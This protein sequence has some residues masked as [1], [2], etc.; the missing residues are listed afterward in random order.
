M[1]FDLECACRF[2]GAKVLPEVITE[3]EEEVLVRSIDQRDGGGGE[4]FDRSRGGVALWT[5]GEVRWSPS[6]S[7]RRKIEYGPRVDFKSQTVIANKFTRNAGPSG[8]TPPK[9]LVN[10][11]SGWH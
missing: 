3:A 7:G 10:S 4:Y 2:A 6:Q 11:R 5:Q 9:R 8:A 1:V